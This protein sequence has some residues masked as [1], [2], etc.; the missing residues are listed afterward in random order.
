MPS[1]QSTRGSSI[2][3][4]GLDRLRTI[5]RELLPASREAIERSR[6]ALERARQLEQAAVARLI[7]ARRPPKAGSER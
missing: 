6:A 5:R 1:D 3:D 7:S 4:G 2:L